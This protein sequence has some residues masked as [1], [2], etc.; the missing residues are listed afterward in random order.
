M[1]GEE[2]DEASPK[3]DGFK[4]ARFSH[5]QHAGFRMIYDP[6]AA[7]DFIGTETIVLYC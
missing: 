1:D 4:E 7:V 6:E 3:S 5:Q 2:E